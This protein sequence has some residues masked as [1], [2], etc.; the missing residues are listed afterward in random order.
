MR[1]LTQRSVTHKQQRLSQTRPRLQNTSS[2]SPIKIPSP[3]ASPSQTSTQTASRTLH[4]HSHSDALANTHPDI[5][6]ETKQHPLKRK[7]CLKHQP[8]RPL[9]LQVEPRPRHQQMPTNTPTQT[10]PRHQPT[11]SVRHQLN[12]PLNFPHKHGRAFT[13]LAHPSNL[14]WDA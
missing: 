4:P 3:S 2:Q 8:P 6:P 1:W 7:H 9:K 12:L 13:S 5:D 11:Y 10:R 14:R